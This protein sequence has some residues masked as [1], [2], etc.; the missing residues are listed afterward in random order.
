MKNGTIRSISKVS[1]SSC[2]HIDVTEPQ[3]SVDCP[4]LQQE[5]SPKEPEIEA[6]VEALTARSSRPHAATQSCPAAFGT[7]R[8]DPDGST[9]FRSHHIKQTRCRVCETALHDL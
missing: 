5:M 4:D 3:E 2:E 7:A 1:R 8:T 9:M 6:G